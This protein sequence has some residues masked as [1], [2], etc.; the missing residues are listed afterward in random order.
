MAVFTTPADLSRLR[1]S[2]KILA[3]AL[4]ATAAAVRPGI[5]TVELNTVADTAIRAQ[6]GTPSFIGYNGYPTA[7]CTSINNEV[8]HGVPRPTRLVQAGDII[9]LDLGVIFEGVFT[10][11]AVTVG[12]GKISKED[13]R[14]IDDTQTAL[15]VGI[16][17]AKAGQRI[18][19][20]SAAIGAYLLPKKYGIVFQLTGHGVGRAIHEAP[21]IPNHGAA[22]VGPM[23]VP[24]MV[25]AIEPMVTRGDRHVETLADGWTVVTVDGSRA[26]HFEHTILVTAEGPEIIT[27]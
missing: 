24:G 17:Q 20:I 10:D 9:G 23:L 19:D 1:H 4:R 18:G 15:A 3:S 13:Q 2:G 22:G 26:A 27:A 8:V 12:A 7:L 21:N 11:H 25:L 5:S 14:L 16:E 6:G